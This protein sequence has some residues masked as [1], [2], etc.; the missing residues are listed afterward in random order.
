MSERELHQTHVAK[1]RVLA[2]TLFVYIYAHL[3]EQG[4]NRSPIPSTL[5]NKQPGTY[6]PFLYSRNVLHGAGML[7]FA[8]A[9]LR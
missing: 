1:R 5:A 7:R 9:L 8:F 2:M 6:L 3:R 4:S